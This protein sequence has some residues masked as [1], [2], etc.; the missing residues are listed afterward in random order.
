M[1]RDRLIDE[2]E[3]LYRRSYRRF[4]RVA[5]AVVGDES[6]GHDVVQEA[7]ARA[8]RLGASYRG[9]GTVEAWLW[10]VLVNAAR[11]AR[12]PRN[13]VVEELSTAFADV[14]GVSTDDE[15][16]RAWVA[17]LPERQR[18]AV[19]LRYYADLDY[20]TIARVLRIRR[21][22]VSATLN[23]AHAAIRRLVEEDGS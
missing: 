20:E 15:R 1:D 7:F 6:V 2:L 4:L 13:E 21:G 14:G 22:T 11:A 3:D 17:A 16:V 19:F 9:D 8:I 10:R 5:I 23:H 12:Q 18:L